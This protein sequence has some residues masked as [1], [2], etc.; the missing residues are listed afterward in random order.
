MARSVSR[1]RDAVETVHLNH[2]FEDADWGWTEFI[3]DLRDNVLRP[4]YPSLRPCDRWSGREDHVILAS[5]RFEISVAEYNGI[6]AVCLAP[7]DA[8]NPLDLRLVTRMAAGFR[9]LLT[10][11]FPASALVSLG[12]A[13]NGEE[14]FRLVAEPGSAV[15]SK[16]G[17]LW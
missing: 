8:D 9:A 12:S 2:P 14:L 3:E 15:T 13:S 10:K 5:E 11:A 6:V 17:R 7:R 16:E 4:R 1:H